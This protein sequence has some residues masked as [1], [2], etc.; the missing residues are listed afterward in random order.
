MIKEK[1]EKLLKKIYPERDDFSEAE[2][3]IAE[4]VYIALR[5]K[6]AKSS[7]KFVEVGS[8]VVVNGERYRCVVR[9]HIGQ[10]RDACMGCDFKGLVCPA[11]LQCSAY[12][13]SDGEYVWF[14]RV[15]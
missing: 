1:V 8:T 6:G 14:R 5:F 11:Y 10:P 15:K 7:S 3:A 9:P 2:L 12:D 13:R 4:D